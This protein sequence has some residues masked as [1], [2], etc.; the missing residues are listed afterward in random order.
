M[1]LLKGTTGS[2]NILYVIGPGLLIAATG[3]GAG[4]LA[5]GAFA[6]SKLGTT[7]LWAVILG[8][9]LKFIVTEG[10]ARWQLATDGT[11]LEGAVKNLGKSVQYIFLLYLTIWSFCVGSALISACGV[12]T[13]A[14]FPIFAPVT[15]KIVF[16]IAHSLVGLI[17]VLT[18]TYKSF[19]KI[20]SVCVGLMVVTVLV[21]VMRL[22]PDWALVVRGMVIP[23]IP[24]YF[25][26]GGSD[27]GA[28]WT[29]AL[30]GGVGGTLTILCYGYWLRE[31]ERNST[32]FLPLCRI[33]LIV[34]YI[35]T[36][37][38]GI[39]MV[40][41]ASSSDIDKQSSAKMVVVLADQLREPIGTIGRLIF[42]IGA[43]AAVFS[44][45][46]GVWQA[47]PYL[48]ADF[49]RLFRYTKYTDNKSSNVRTVDVT[50]RPYRFYLFGIALIPIIG[51][52]YQFVV[53]Q[54]VYAV[55]GS[56]IIPML[57]IVLLILNGRTKFIGAQYK[58][59]CITT[60]MLILILIIFL[61]IG[62]PN[63]VLI[64]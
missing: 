15:G 24:E 20:M 58:N 11:L 56:L 28:V 54:K 44:S 29:L 39:A 19:E 3:V 47:V 34:A 43:W 7:V 40:I 42:L 27:Q 62:G 38:F 53:I 59:K 41:I 50:S 9:A 22:N 51:L 60:G 8:A 33:D 45:L 5:G 13:T 6:G 37:L 35:I 21:T 23:R 61:Y 10:L 52:R 49:W 26:E 55:L 2:Q 14:L 57:A 16:G 48:F 1:R 63:I 17:L 36:A 64:F 32:K 4:D 30:M 12:A 46:L 31:K 18:G 25:G